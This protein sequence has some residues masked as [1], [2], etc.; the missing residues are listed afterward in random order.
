MRLLL[1][2]RSHYRYTKPTKL[3]THT[4]RLHPASHAKATIETY[5]LAC[6]QAERIIWTMDPH[7]NRVAQVTFPWSRGLSELDILVEMAV[8]IRPV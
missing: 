6:E 4:L 8:E 1:Q 3:G 5:R 2:H 7:G